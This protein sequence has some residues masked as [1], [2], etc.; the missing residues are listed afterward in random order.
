MR[1][2]TISKLALVILTLVMSSSFQALADDNNAAP[3]SN[4]V[5]TAQPNS[6]PNAPP[7]GS[8]SDKREAVI[9]QRQEN[10][11][12]RIEQGEKSGELTHREA[13]K[14]EREQAKV[15]RMESRAEADGKVT[16]GEAKRIENAQNEASQDIY[17]KKHNSRKHK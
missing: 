10:Q 13:K 12:K 5:G 7:S 3:I 4:E 9:N 11:N 16:K 15:N 6:P 1:T 17:K 14:L 2:I 8:K